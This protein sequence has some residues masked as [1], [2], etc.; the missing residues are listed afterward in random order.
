MA[1]V[2]EPTLKGHKIVSR[3]EWNAARAQFLKKEKEFTHQREA[4][5]AELRALPWAKVEKNY[6][7]DTNE[8]KKSLRDLFNGKS[9]L[10]TYHFMFGP[11]WDE[12]CDGCSFVSDHV[13]SARQHFEHHDI[14]YVAVSRATL[15]K[16]NAYKKRMGWTFPWV[17][18]DDGDFNYDFQASFRQED[19]EEGPVYYNFKMQK[20]TGDEQPGLSVFYKDETGDIYHTYS[21]YE[22]GLDILLT[23]YHFI[24]MTPI[25]RNEKGNGMGEWMK[26]HDEY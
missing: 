20:L 11:D 4:M 25:G 10:I 3:D 12:G 22:R 21:T 2:E 17:S 16:L 19:L 5:A 26:R 1:L 14:S 9:Q 6:V 13:D 18:S 24:D 15:D 23:T 8:G 7:F